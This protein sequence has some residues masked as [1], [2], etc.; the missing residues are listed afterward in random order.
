MSRETP[1]PL[2]L[3]DE[4]EKGRR[5]GGATCALLT[6]SVKEFYY[7]L[8]CKHIFHDELLHYFELAESK[9]LEYKM[10]YYGLVISR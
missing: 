4:R 7:K 9:I 6:P 5:E 3:E 10:I 8:E 1:P 2:P